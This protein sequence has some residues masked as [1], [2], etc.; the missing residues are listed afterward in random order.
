MSRQRSDE[1]IKISEFISIGELV[2]LTNMRYSTLKFYT[3]EGFIPFLQEDIKMVR[4]YPRE[5]AILRIEEII[6]MRKDNLSIDEIRKELIK[7][8]FKI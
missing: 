5:K 1:V 2:R 7:S 8:D 3:E 4:R 6:Q